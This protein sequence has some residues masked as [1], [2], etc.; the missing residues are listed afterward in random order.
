MDFTG[1]MSAVAKQIG[2]TYTLKGRTVANAEVFGVAGLLP[3]LV[4]RA[5]QLSSLCF[6]YGL[7]ATYDDAEASL[8]GVKVTFDEFTPDTLRLLCVTDVLYE[9][10]RASP[11]S[12]EVSLDELLYD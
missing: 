1:K 3:G 10:V 2:V 4:K 5:D 12:T 11:S 6:G 7:G 8:L 9:I